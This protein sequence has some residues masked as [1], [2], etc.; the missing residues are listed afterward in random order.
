MAGR[1]KGWEA[2]GI[3]RMAETYCSLFLRPGQCAN[4][5]FLLGLAAGTCLGGGRQQ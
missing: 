4:K 2:E 1:G 5:H 3:K